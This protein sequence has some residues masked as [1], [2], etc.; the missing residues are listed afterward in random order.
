METHCSTIVQFFGTLS[1]LLERAGGEVI[2]SV[3]LW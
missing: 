2:F 3:S 1:S